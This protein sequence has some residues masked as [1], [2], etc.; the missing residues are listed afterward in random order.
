MTIFFVHDHIVPHFY[1]FMFLRVRSL[2]TWDEVLFST[3]RKVQRERLFMRNL[4]P[5]DIFLSNETCIRV[6]FY[7]S[8]K[9]LTGKTICIS[10]DLH[11]PLLGFTTEMFYKNPISRFNFLENG[12]FSRSTVN[13]TLKAVFL[14]GI[15]R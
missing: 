7:A 5:P 15:C 2:T 11:V 3:E 6:I 4:S 10:H 9:I 1:F 14:T 12:G 8:M 13:G